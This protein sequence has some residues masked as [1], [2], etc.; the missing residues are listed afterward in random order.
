MAVGAWHGPIS[1]GGGLVA[2]ARGD[3]RRGW[4][5]VAGTCRCRGRGL[6]C[7]AQAWRGGRGQRLRRPRRRRGLGAREAGGHGGAPPAGRGDDAGGG[8]PEAVWGGRQG[9]RRSLP[10][11]SPWP[12]GSR[13]ALPQP[14]VRGGALRRRRAGGQGQQ[15]GAGDAHGLQGQ[16]S[17]AWQGCRSGQLSGATGSR[18][19]CQLSDRPARR[20]WSTDSAERTACGGRAFR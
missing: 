4:L 5:C 3:P 14:G 11:A 10:R 20:R 9:G 19:A 7:L 16:D 12:G 6:H 13:G 2:G 8:A 1:G 15:P 18:G 17:S